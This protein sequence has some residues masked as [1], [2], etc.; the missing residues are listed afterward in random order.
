[1]EQHLTVFFGKCYIIMKILLIWGKEIQIMLQIFGLFVELP[2]SK[3]LDRSSTVK[4][5]MSATFRGKPN[6]FSMK[7]FFS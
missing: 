7:K 5:Q 4:V 1:M 3:Y 6:F 2:H